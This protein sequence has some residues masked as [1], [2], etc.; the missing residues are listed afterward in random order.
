MADSNSDSE[1]STTTSFKGFSEGGKSPRGD[2]SPPAPTAPTT[3]RLLVEKDQKV[4]LR[5]ILMLQL[6]RKRSIRS[7]RGRNISHPLQ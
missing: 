2:P 6:Q 3:K 7:K 5:W 4:V 1:K